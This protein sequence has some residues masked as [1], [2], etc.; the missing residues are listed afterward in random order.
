MLVTTVIIGITRHKSK[1]LI[2]YLWYWGPLC[3]TQTNTNYHIDCKPQINGH[4]MATRSH[5]WC[6][7]ELRQNTQKSLHNEF[8][9]LGYI[10]WTFCLTWFKYSS[11]LSF[12]G[13]ANQLMKK[14]YWRLHAKNHHP[15]LAK[16]GVF[17][18][19]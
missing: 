3:N 9:A 13:L 10:Y 7:H 2:F 4:K 1:T 15:T 14:C 8:L 17:C 5:F 18:K 19:R 11:Q 16:H 12:S 6:T